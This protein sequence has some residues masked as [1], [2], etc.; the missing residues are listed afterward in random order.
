MTPREKT[1][2][3]LRIQSWRRGMKEVDLL[4]GRFIEQFSHSLT[5]YEI[6]CY[7]KFLLEDDQRIFSWISKKTVVPKEFSFI[8]EKIY[9]SMVINSSTNYKNCK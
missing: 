6:T 4:L 9:Q 5:D 2:K 3:R 1:I 7:E 8:I